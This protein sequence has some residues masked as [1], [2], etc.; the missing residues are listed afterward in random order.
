VPATDQR[1]DPRPANSIDV[2]AFQTQPTP[3]PTP[4]PSPTPSPGPSPGHAGFNASEVALDALLVADGLVNHNAFLVAW[5]L[6]DYSKLL[7]TLDGSGQAQAQTAFSQDFALDVLFL[8]GA[9]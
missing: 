5:G 3:V 8:H 4:S 6:G 1:G 9:A 7:G 2:G